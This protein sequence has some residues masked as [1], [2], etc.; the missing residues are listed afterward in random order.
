MDREFG[1][2]PFVYLVRSKTTCFA[3]AIM[4]VVQLYATYGHVVWRVSVDS[5]SVETSAAV[6]AQLN[7]NHIE[8]HPAAP[9][10]QYQNATER[11]IQ[12]ATKTVATMLAAQPHIDETFWGLALL[13]Y[14][15]TALAVPSVAS[16]EFSP[17]Y[18][19]TGY[20]P[21]LQKRFLFPFGQT[22][23]SRIPE[24]QRAFKFNPHGEL[25]IAVGSAQGGMERH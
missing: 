17:W 7:T 6:I 1:V 3:R 11:D 12:T 21:D 24:S 22:V 18:R 16:G 13:S 8:V 23:I 25:G 14:S 2:G 5:G 15:D 20:H 19:I 10:C 4:A 9:G